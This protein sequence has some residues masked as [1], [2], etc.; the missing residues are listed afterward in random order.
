MFDDPRS[1]R[2]ARDRDANARDRDPIDP[3]DAFVDK[4]HLPAGPD[5]EIVRDRDR[6][7][8]LR[9][10][11][12]RTLSIVGSFRVVS[13]Q[14]LRDHDGRPLDANR[15]DLRHLRE[16]GLVRAIQVDGHRDVAVVLTERGRELLESHRRGDD[17]R[18]AG[19]RGGESKAQQTFYADLK[20]PREVEHDM[21]IYRAYEREAARLQER[22][23]RVD[24]V[25]LDY[26]LKREY[27]RF[28]QE[29]N[30]GRGDSDG[31]PDRTPAEIQEWAADHELPYFDGHV[32]FPDARVEY[33][34]QDGRLEHIDI[35]VV[36]LHYRGA[37]G[38]AAGRSGFSKFSGS[39]ARTG[40]SLF[41][42]DYAAEVI[43]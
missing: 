12:S 8:T 16:Q 21:Q 1:S 17:G 7:Y 40:G 42:P 37:H 36:T 19:G 28:L 13:S 11:E 41:D 33:I 39:S 10:S 3:R 29:R 27:Q 5:R 34:D 6:E 38:A 9:D 20:K 22:G 30:R 23:A 15:G 32:H 4:L 24:R 18:D 43:R 2:D 35:E 14:D 25:V 26:E 31:R